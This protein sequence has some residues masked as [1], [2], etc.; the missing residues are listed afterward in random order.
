M[1]V[2]SVTGGDSRD[3]KSKGKGKPSRVAIGSE[4]YLPASENGDGRQ[5]QIRA[6]FPRSPYSKGGLADVDVARTLAPGTVAPV[7]TIAAD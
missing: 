6:R 2:A 5:G 3:R 7:S 1:G 4:P